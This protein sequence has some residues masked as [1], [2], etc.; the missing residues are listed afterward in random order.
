MGCTTLLAL[1]VHG[2]QVSTTRDLGSSGGARHAVS[3][4]LLG[5]H[6]FSRSGSGKYKSIVTSTSFLT[7]IWVK[8]RPR[9]PTDKF[10]VRN[11]K[12]SF[13][14]TESIF[15]SACFHI[16][17]I[18]RQVSEPTWATRV[19]DRLHFVK[20]TQ[21]RPSVDSR[22]CPTAPRSEHSDSYC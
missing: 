9:R 21:R 4:E 17:Q 22:P 20:F 13:L 18:H 3:G 1:L 2:D 12:R 5:A 16:Q 8:R 19:Q 14:T 6:L 7:F 15:A 11:Y 10:A